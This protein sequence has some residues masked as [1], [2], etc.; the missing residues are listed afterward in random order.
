MSPTMSQPLKLSVV[1]LS[2]P[3]AV[4]KTTVTAS[5]VTRLGFERVRSGAF[6]QQAAQR[7]GRP[8]DRAGLQAL[9]DEYDE[10]TDYRWLVDDVAKPLVSSKPRQMRWLIDAV[11]KQRQVQHFRDA[12]GES[13]AHV[14]LT[15]SEETL[16]SRYEARVAAGEEYLGS[17][18]YVL[19]IAHPNEI[20]A[21]NMLVIA[22]VVL[23]VEG[24]SLHS[25]VNEIAGQL[26]YA[27]CV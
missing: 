25:V 5:L 15:A 14:H 2:G 11:R 23:D 24:K 18:P 9:G 16:Q 3:V 19:A 21:R 7:L 1:L 22:D 20:A 4:G 26:G 13:V 8:S 10:S 6:L 27:D 17:T 12:F